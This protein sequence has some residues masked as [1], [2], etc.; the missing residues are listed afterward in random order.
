MC[1][2]SFKDVY[3]LGRRGL[4]VSLP[5]WKQRGRATSAACALREM[6]VMRELLASFASS[7]CDSSSSASG[8]FE[9]H[10]SCSARAKLAS[11]VLAV[12]DSGSRTGCASLSGTVNMLTVAEDAGADAT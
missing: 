8:G 5:Q 9:Q 6:L 3:V 7:K 1:G 11:A 10:S 4:S 12:D 2:L